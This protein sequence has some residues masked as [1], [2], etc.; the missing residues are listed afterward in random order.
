MHERRFFR[1]RKSKI[2][3]TIGPSTN[4]PKMIERLARS[5]MD[6]ARLNFSHGTPD[7]HLQVI[8]NIR[9]VSERVGKQIAIMQDLPGPKMRVG[10]LQGGSMA[11]RRGSVVTLITGEEESTVPDVIPVHVEKLAKYVPVGATVF[12]SD[13]LIRLRVIS[14]TPRELKCRCLNGGQLLSGKGV[15]IPDLAKGFRAFTDL[16]QKYLLFG[17]K[18]KVDLVA[19]SFV[20]SAEEIRR[21]KAFI[22]ASMKKG[23]EE[24]PWIVAKIERREAVENMDELIEASDAVMVARGDLGVENPVERVPIIQKELISACNIGAVPVITATQ[25]LESMVSNPRP[26]RAE[27]TDV[28]NAVFD[29]TDALMLSEET[30]IGQFP[31]ECV[32][33][34]DNV[35]RSAEAWLY[36]RPAQK[37]HGWFSFSVADR[38]EDALSEAATRLS[39]EVRSKLIVCPTSTG[40]LARRISRERPSADIIA[41]TDNETTA[42]KLEIVNG[43]HSLLVRNGDRAGEKVGQNWSIERAMKIVSR[44]IQ[45][46]RLGKVGDRIVLA[47]DSFEQINQQGDLLLVMELQGAK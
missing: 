43:V 29:G 42:R 13:G 14:K 4:S 19:V 44:V 25:M 33:T 28:A 17:L 3:C 10:K 16:D 31:I 2:V 12:L 27:A 45:D 38:T 24:A 32:K 5:G 35:A 7:R 1:R 15:N 37:S 21:V 39:K 26:T 47:R 34:L 18:N 6:C 36:D 40:E 41:L 8:Q 20:K 11:L 23:S 30:A 22:A 46:N 9:I